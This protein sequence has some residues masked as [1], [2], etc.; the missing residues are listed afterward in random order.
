VSSWPS[1]QPI[2]VWAA[3]RAWSDQLFLWWTLDALAREH[4]DLSR[5]YRAAPVTYHPLAATGGA[6]RPELAR[7]LAQAQPIAPE[8]VDASRELWRSFVSPSPLPFDEL[9]RADP[10]SIPDLASIA[11]PHGWW[12]PRLIDGRL[13]LSE[14]D[15][16]LLYAFDGEWRGPSAL[17]RGT[18][19]DDITDRLINVYGDW[20]IVA[21]L[22]EW[23]GRGV[24]EY[25]RR[26]GAG[27]GQHAF[28]ITDVGCRLRDECMQS[29]ADAPAIYTGGC[30][31]HDPARPFVRVVE[32]GGWRLAL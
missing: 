27:W 24:L 9:R 10:S 16:L 5:V 7:A 4:V 23:V 18:R 25:Q 19:T 6:P 2:V 28:R 31:T 3:P 1:T 26:D 21:R 14:M 8:L 22:M 15:E 20:I 12:F 17:L 30:R 13:R 29:V 11:E 32:S